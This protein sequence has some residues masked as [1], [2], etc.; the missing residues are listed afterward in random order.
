MADY[1]KDAVDFMRDADEADSLNRVGMM[2][3]LRFS[4]GDQW[5]TEVENS[6]FLEARPCLTI[7]KTDPYIR[8]I[9]NQMRQQRPRGR[10]HP[11]D[12][13]GDPKIAE[14]IN[15]LFRHIEANSNAEFAYDKAGDFQVRI[16]LGYWRLR[17]DYIAE[18]S[19]DQEIFI[20]QIDNP[21][22]VY[23]DR[24]STLPDGSDMKKGLITDLMRKED[25]KRAYPG[26][27]YQGFEPTEGSYSPAWI[28][29]NDIRI[30]EYFCI[31]SE[32]KKL[33]ALTDGTI[34]WEDRL[35]N[36]EL[37]ASAGVSISGSRDSNRSKVIWS[38]VT[39]I[40]TL[41]EKTLPGRYI[42]LIPVYGADIICDSERVIFGV[43]R[44]AKDPAR[45]YNFWRTAMTE[46]MAMT[47]KAKWLI[48]E[49]G[50]EGHENEY[51]Q[52]NV[53]AIP[54][55]RYKTKD[56]K[57]VPLPA[58][59]YIQ[60]EGPP[61]GF[62]S[63]AASFSDDLQSVMGMYDPA[64]GKPSGQKS[65]KAIIAEQTQSDQSNFHFYDNLTR[66]M[67]HSYR[68]AL[69]WIPHIYDVERVMRIIGEDGRPD[70]VTLNQKVLQEGVQKVLNDVTVG[71]YDVV[72]ETGPGYN[73]KRQEGVE[74]MM[75]LL[76]TPLGEKVAATA[77]DLIVRQMDYPGSDLVADRLAAANPLSQIDDKSDI[78]PQVQM[79]I[80]GL[81]QQLQQSGQ[82]IQ[83]LQTELQTKA[84]IEKMKQEAA[85]Q[86]TLITATAYAHATET[87]SQGEVD[88]RQVS[89][90]TRRHD[91]ET[92]ALASL[93]VAEMNNITQ[94]LLKKMDIAQLE[95]IARREDAE[96][97]QKSAETES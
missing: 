29:D 40:E 8:Q 75:Q 72:M 91:A 66:S 93:S 88:E 89:A 18:D 48:P 41:E 15:G 63:M 60:P 92:K 69:D 80:K 50:D 30:A 76:N 70:M 6:R 61:L 33:V 37:L 16:G 7:N 58:P 94:L 47:P 67:N 52:A 39:A 9:T 46:K 84:G 26:A 5:P 45:M 83:S 11:V 71:S 38:K 49:G 73:S 25:F 97:L 3:D 23:R 19:F 43:V 57:G 55:L 79:M 96:L 20:D 24:N 22:S 54:T 65:G 59:I 64:M 86:R 74:A 35:P 27:Q 56:D 78:P 82:M 28:T 13:K 68:I 44:N 17:T 1:S 12:S 2:E 85:T 14:I 42:P 32:S 62:M 36:K 51:A 21:F 4:L 53:S 34:T 87:D 95:G 77:D 81:Q 31:E 10:A 90:A